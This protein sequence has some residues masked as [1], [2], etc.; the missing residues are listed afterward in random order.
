MD[1]LYNV[2]NMNFISEDF[3]QFT[4]PGCNRMEFIQSYLN[5][6]GID[7]PVIQLEDK[8]HIYVKF[9]QSQYNPM[10]RIKTVIAHYDRFEGSMGANDNSAAVY[11]LLEWA[12]KLS[13]FQGAHNIRLIFTDGEE[14]MEG[15]VNEQGAFALAQ[16]FRKLGI[17]NDD[18]FVFDCVGRGDVPVICETV[19]PPGAGRSFIAQMNNLESLAE[20]L[21]IS[22]G[23]GKWFK[24]PANYSDNAGFIANGIPA[25]AITMLPSVEI[26]QALRGEKP[27]TWKKLHTFMDN[28]ESLTPEAFGIF[29]NILNNLAMLKDFKN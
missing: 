7:A 10:F 3:K 18:I 16:L 6:A 1:L 24:L 27:D 12:V 11:C 17:V 21:V 15:G 8:N 9:S 29:N 20:K 19:I 13:R 22:A 5:K 26:S 14:S 23:N 4:S 2:Q 28:L 25:V